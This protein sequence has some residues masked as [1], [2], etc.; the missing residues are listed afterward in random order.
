MNHR[1]Y[2][3][4]HHI[5]LFK[6]EVEK[7]DIL[8]IKDLKNHLSFGSFISN[9]VY[10]KSGSGAFNKM[11]FLNYPWVIQNGRYFNLYNP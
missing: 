9:P 2:L 3:F 1:K 11:V 8:L 5:L 6:K 10:N 4:E 7:T